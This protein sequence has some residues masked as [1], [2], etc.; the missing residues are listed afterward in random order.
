MKFFTVRVYKCSKNPFALMVFLEEYRE[1]EERILLQ[2]NLEG[3]LYKIAPS[4]MELEEAEEELKQQKKKTLDILEKTIWM[5]KSWF[6]RVGLQIIGKK[7]VFLESILQDSRYRAHEVCQAP[8]RR[9]DLYEKQVQIGNDLNEIYGA[10]RKFVVKITKYQQEWKD[11]VERLRY[12]SE[13]IRRIEKIEATTKKNEDTLTAFQGYLQNYLLLNEEE[14]KKFQDALKSMSCY[15][16]EKNFLTLE[17][18]LSRHILIEIAEELKG[19]MRT[20]MYHSLDQREVLI[21]QKERLKLRLDFLSVSVKEVDFEFKRMKRQG[22]ALK[23]DFQAL[24]MAKTGE[25]L[26]PQIIEQIKT[27]EKH[28]QETLELLKKDNEAQQREVQTIKHSHDEKIY[29]EKVEGEVE[30]LLR[31]KNVP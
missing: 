14:R 29:E 25:L 5:E 4:P 12:S 27:A 15:Q 19:K 11:K 3:E 1:V 2:E 22:Y 18:S 20:E 6:E 28:H 24:G 23:Y 17:D 30:A 31:G 26:D 8:L 13:N 21:D 16:Q 10:L 7:E 9:Y